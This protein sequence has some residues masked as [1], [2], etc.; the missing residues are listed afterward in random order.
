M[1]QGDSLL[2]CFDLGNNTGLSSF[3]EKKEATVHSWSYE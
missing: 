2:C 1:S 3:V